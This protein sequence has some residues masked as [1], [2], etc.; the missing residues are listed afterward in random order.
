MK[1][2]QDAAHDRALGHP[3]DQAAADRAADGEQ[4]QLLAQER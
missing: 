1:L 3:Q 2:L 4:L